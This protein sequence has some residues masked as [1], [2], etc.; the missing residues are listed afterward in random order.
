MARESLTIGGLDLMAGANWDVE[1]IQITSPAPVG[2]NPIVAG[3]IGS[4]WHAKSLG[5]AGFTVTMWIGNPSYT[6]QQV[7]VLWEQIAAAVWQPETLLTAVW[8]LSDGAT[9]TA[10]VELVGDVAP[11]RIGTKGWRVTLEF[12]I[13]SGEWT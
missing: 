12:G 3:R 10:Q 4:L 13:P 9:R 11:Q 2:D 6:R 8:T 5:Q 1:D 7:W